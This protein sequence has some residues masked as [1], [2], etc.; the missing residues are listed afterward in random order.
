MRGVALW[1]GAEIAIIPNED[2]RDESRSGAVLEQKPSRIKQKIY[3][4]ANDNMYNVKKKSYLFMPS[5]PQSYL[6]FRAL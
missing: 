5:P 3:R 2:T 4:H 6:L 1:K